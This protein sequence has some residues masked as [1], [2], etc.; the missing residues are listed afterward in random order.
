MQFGIISQFK[1][2]LKGVRRYDES[3][4]FVSQLGC[5]RI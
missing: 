1:A 5:I 4:T 2:L 3:S